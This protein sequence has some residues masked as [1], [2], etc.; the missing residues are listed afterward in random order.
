MRTVKKSPHY[1]VRNAHS[2]CVRV[3]VPKDLQRFIGRREL[4]YSLKTG[5]LGVA[6]GKAQIISA[7][8]HQVYSFLRKEGAKLAVLTDEQVQELVQ[9]YLK[10]YIESLESRYFE[11]DSPLQT[12][13]DFDGYVGTLDAVREDIVA[14]LG[15]G[16]YGT[17]E[18]SVA[19]LLAEHGIDEIATGSP[20]WVKLC[21]GVLRAQLQGIEIEKQQMSRGL[22]EGP[23]EAFRE[24]RSN[25]LS[26]PAGVERSSLVSEVVSQYVDET[27]KNWRTKTKE[28]YLA[29]FNVFIE[30]VGDLPINTITRKMVGAFKQTLMKLPRNIK[31][32]PKYRKKTI[33]ELAQ[34]E[35]PERISGTTIR[36]YLSTVGTLFE[37]A[38]KNG[39]YDGEN[40]ATGMAP[41]M[42][43]RAHEARAPFDEGDLIKL[44]HS[45][46]Y[47]EDSFTRPYQFWM[48]ILALYTGARLNELAQLHLSDIKQAEDGTWVFDINDEGEKAL[49]TKSSRRIIPIHPVLLNDLNLISWVNSL[50]TKGEQRLF[51]GLKKGRDGYGRNV[52]KW[53][54][55]R[56]RQRCGIVIKDRKK[57]FHSFRETFI[58]RLVHQG[59]NDRM[60]LQVEG[61]SAGKD[62]T[63]VYADPFPA[64]KLY[65]EVIL[66]LDYG[67]DLSHLK[68][69]KFVVKN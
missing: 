6:R 27:Q 65:D 7:Q 34:M 62:M 50:K 35:V 13:A 57:D 52:S 36:K 4:R 15:L 16:D 3:N 53:F 68:K 69:S 32:N 45:E 55:E 38:R 20:E 31:K 59:V 61:H 48:P 54:N 5:Y 25:G 17:V 56:Y 67:I 1:L 33:Q 2:Y 63:S 39:L 60:R 58:T 14:Y 24:N 21:R 12:R 49:K 66:K 46:G 44:F 9:Q 47:L 64:R 40:P 23:G 41:R 19:S 28:D 51:P 18:K 10:Q 8:I 22:R 37:Y 11:E 42:D 29:I 30:V 43:K 26:T